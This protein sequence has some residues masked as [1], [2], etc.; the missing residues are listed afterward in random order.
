MTTGKSLT[1]LCL[2]GSFR[3][4]CDAAPAEVCAG[5][6]RL[7][8]Y[9]GLHRRATR[10]ALAGTLWPDATE[11]RA[12]GCLRTT[13]WRL[14]RVNR[15]LVLSDR[16]DLSLA[17]SVDVDTRAFVRS[18]LRPANS[19]ACDAYDDELLRLL[20]PE[21]DLL[22]GWEED[23]VGFERE[24]LRQLRL[25]ALDSLA[26]RL[27]TRGRHT[28][29]LEAALASARSAPLRESAHRTV[30]SVYLARDDP[31][32]AVRHYNAFRELV[33]DRHGLLPSPLFSSM[34][35]PALAQEPFAV[36][37]GQNPVATVR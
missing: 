25:H 14:G 5:A 15:P 29:A 4:D 30:V 22:P 33:R 37:G 21:A 32:E 35:A 23:W 16:G 2:R 7:L 27:A 3:L 10:V 20:L 8:A 28:L 18:V 31:A 26:E 24:H 11:E 12:Q 13:L 9:L 19:P 6:R 36:E 1:R 34:L 17:E